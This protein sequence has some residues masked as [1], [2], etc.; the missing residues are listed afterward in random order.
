MYCSKEKFTL[1]EQ[2]WMQVSFH[3]VWIIGAIAIFR[4]SWIIALLYTILFPFVGVL[5]GI[6]HTW[7]CPRCP[8]IKNHNSCVQL[9]PFVAKKIITKYKR[10]RLNIYEKI[11]FFIVLYG[12]LLF[13]VYWI[14]K[15]EI[16]I[17]PFFIFATTHYLA[18]Y[19]YFCKRCL[20]RF[21]PQ[22][23]NKKIRG[24]NA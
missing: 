21:C 9:H 10:S 2:I 6:M 8:H 15:T 5:Y 24:A 11:G 12:M 22:N 17:I 16:L 14:L 23:M 18:Y 20:N 19:F 4:E 1:F 13:P 3:G 7:I